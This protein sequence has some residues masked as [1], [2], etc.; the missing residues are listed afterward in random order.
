MSLRLG[1]I[2]KKLPHSYSKLLHNA[3]GCEY[4]LFELSKEDLESFARE[5]PLD[6]FNVTVPYKEEIMKYLGGISPEA[7]EAGAVNTVVRHD[8]RLTGYNTDIA[9][10]KYAFERGKI[11]IGGRRVMILGSGGTGKTARLLCGKLGASGIITVSRGGSVNYNNIHEYAKD[12]QVLINATPVGMYPDN[13][14]SPVSL[15]G[16]T[17]LEGVFDAV[18]NPLKTMLLAEAESMGVKAVNGAAMLAAQAKYA[19]DI[20]AGKVSG[21]DIEMLCALLERNMRNIVFVGMPSSGK[22]TTGRL[23]AEMLG[24]AF[25]D[26][27][28]EI[29]KT[30]GMSAEGIIR[31]KGERAFRD[32]ESASIKNLAKKTGIVLST[33]GGSVLRKE[34]IEALRQ[35]G[36]IIWLRRPLELLSTDGRPLSKNLETLRAM[37]NVREGLYR[38][39]AHIII[40]ND[41]DTAACMKKI[42]EA[43]NE[44]FG[45]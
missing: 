34:N 22:S 36:I 10:M 23:T 9:G 7:G 1:L 43:L 14:G 16:F 18:Y 6:G 42:V 25:F 8:G 30:E 17:S 35:N 3:M 13:H 20:F 45:Y 21:T 11:E 40:D 39:A 4:E 15:S 31:E 32:T 26:S 44:N 19:N 41:E 2:G 28:E 29:E 5:N 38:A 12:I 37:Y 33:G 24:R 27:D